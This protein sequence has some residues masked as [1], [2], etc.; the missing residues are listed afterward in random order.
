MFSLKPA[1]IHDLVFI[2]FFTSALSKPVHFKF[3]F[4]I[5]RWCAPWLKCPA[6][7]NA[8]KTI[9]YC[10]KTC[11]KQIIQLAHNKAVNKG[12]YKIMFS[13][14][15][16]TI[17]C[18]KSTRILLKI[19]LTVRNFCMH[20]IMLT[21]HIFSLRHYN[22]ISIISK[23][24]HTHLLAYKNPANTSLMTNNEC[25]RLS[26][27]TLNYV[28]ECERSDTRN[29]N[30]IA[31]AMSRFIKTLSVNTSWLDLHITDTHRNTRGRHRT[32]FVT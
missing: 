28:C 10:L 11:K 12:Q 30:T 5:T 19:I 14:P 32:P 3:Y 21:G 9:S 2:E 4:I 13:G 16:L 25:V 20:V 27:S 22:I 6:L 18:L 15:D 26:S 29:L 17:L 1:Y 8:S 23:T 7:F 24:N 31:L